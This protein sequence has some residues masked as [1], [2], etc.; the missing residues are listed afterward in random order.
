MRPRIAQ[1]P[2]V[3]VSERHEDRAA[4]RVIKDPAVTFVPPAEVQ[5]AGTADIHSD[6]V[7][8]QAATLRRGSL[9]RKEVQAATH[10]SQASAPSPRQRGGVLRLKRLAAVLF[11]S[12]GTYLGVD[13]FN[14]DQ[15]ADLHLK[16][17]SLVDEPNS[18]AAS[19][20][21]RTF[22]QKD[23]SSTST[24][25]TKM[26][27]VPVEF[28]ASLT[29]PVAVAR[30]APPSKADKPAVSPMIESNRSADVAPETALPKATVEVALQGPSSASKFEPAE[31]KDTIAQLHFPP[32]LIH[33]RQHI[34]S[35]VRATEAE[36]IRRGAA[37]KAPA[38][39]ASIAEA[40]APGSSK[41][42]GNQTATVLPAIVP[43]SPKLVRESLV[44]TA[45]LAQPRGRMTD[46][47]PHGEPAAAQRSRQAIHDALADRGAGA[48]AP[49][50]G[51]VAQRSGGA[52]PRK[53][54]VAALE[55]SAAGSSAAVHGRSA[56]R[57]AHA[58][59]GKESIALAHARGQKTALASGG[60]NMV[61]L[62]AELLSGRATLG[63][64]HLVPGTSD[65]FD[66][67]SAERAPIADTDDEG[68]VRFLGL[69]LRTSQPAWA[70]QILQRQN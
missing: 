48:P 41:Q 14:S 6:P 10:S 54:R 62:H 59:L 51:T 65:R 70:R 18:T 12:T 63:R 35:A 40:M 15:L 46:F 60:R 8:W 24:G 69:R 21:D 50:S 66:E 17:A 34:S 16:L 11:L 20:P 31:T 25:G 23:T 58:A 43:P 53:A 26:V 27:A 56:E 44:R 55:K 29:Q 32:V 33:K 5:G 37:V 4:A 36:E 38:S 42:A 57:H 64:G 7:A 67:T 61:P 22:N 39:L 49:S 30:P 52:S 9:P 19:T 45:E 28:P 47:S 13:V 2:L 68:Y 1:K 3:D